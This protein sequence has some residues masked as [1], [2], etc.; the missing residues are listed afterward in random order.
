MNA[1]VRKEIRLLLPMWVVTL[2]LALL[3]NL[4]NAVSRV[5]VAADLIAPVLIF[6]TG[7]SGLLLGLTSF[8]REIYTN[9]FSLLLAQPRRR[10]DLWRTKIKV[11][12]G[13]A[14]LL[15]LFLVLVDRNF[16]P[17]KDRGTAAPCWGWLLWSRRFR[18]GCWTTLAAASGHRGL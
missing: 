10:T 17:M 14:G 15:S 2:L 9:T 4:L 6:V 18:V 1:L 8:G 5:G 16:V 7:I 11:L 12:L 3:P 13:A